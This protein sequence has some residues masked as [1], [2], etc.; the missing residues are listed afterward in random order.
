MGKILQT[1]PAMACMKTL[2][3]LFNVTFWVRIIDYSKA[4]ILRVNGVVVANV[5]NVK[6]RQLVWLYCVRVY[7]CK[8]NF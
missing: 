5:G 2:L 7:G 1:V 6:N 8:L 3:M 4:V